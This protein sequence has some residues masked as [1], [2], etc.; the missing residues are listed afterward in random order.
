MD[1]RS[2]VIG[3]SLSWVPHLSGFKQSHG[4]WEEGQD[5]EYAEYAYFISASDAVPA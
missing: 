2:D 4:G 5:V 3:G 1:G